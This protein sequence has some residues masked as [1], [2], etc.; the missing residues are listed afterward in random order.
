MTILLVGIFFSGCS[1][2]DTA[3]MHSMS[4][5]NLLGKWKLIKTSGGFGGNITEFDENDDSFVVEFQK[6]DFIRSKD[7]KELGR[8]KYRIIMGKS[9]RSTEDIPLI[10]Y[11]TGRKQSFEFRNGNLIL[12]DECYDCFQNEY[13]AL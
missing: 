3:E 5:E 9:I 7:G 12:F 10:I 6:D 13:I 1:L 2:D 11:E 8:A 4:N